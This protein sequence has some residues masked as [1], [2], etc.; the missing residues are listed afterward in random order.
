MKQMNSLLTS[1]KKF[2]QNV[3][4]AHLIYVPNPGK[5]MFISFYDIC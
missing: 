2:R 5:W 1:F 3:I 4:R